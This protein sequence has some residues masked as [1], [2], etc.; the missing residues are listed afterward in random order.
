MSVFN[1]LLSVPTGNKTDHSWEIL[2]NIIQGQYAVLHDY[3]IEGEGQGMITNHLVD[4]MER[5]L[6]RK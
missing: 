6:L 5:K 1:Q 4:L 2:L 3:E